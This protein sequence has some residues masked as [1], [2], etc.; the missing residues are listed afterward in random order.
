MTNDA[1][2][3]TR[4]KPWCGVVAL[5]FA[6]FALGISILPSWIESVDELDEKTLSE[7]LSDKATD[8]KES[9]MRRFRGEETPEVIEPEKEVSWEKI[10]AVG[11]VA[12]GFTAVVLGII[13]YVRREDLRLG[14]TAAVIGVTAIAW[15]NLF[16][17]VALGV[18]LIVIGL[19]VRGLAH[20][21][22]G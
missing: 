3:K 22:P 11:G 7:S 18:M 14:A 8:A 17:A 5:T 2:Q 12:L 20:A 13:A 9:L 6:L 19:V 15:H 21:E 1:P 10:S 16:A 4:P